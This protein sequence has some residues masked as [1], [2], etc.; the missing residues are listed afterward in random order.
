MIYKTKITL[1]IHLVLIQYNLSQIWYAYLKRFLRH[2]LS[3]FQVYLKWKWFFIWT[4]DECVNL[5][6]KLLS[7]THGVYVMIRQFASYLNYILLFTTISRIDLVWPKMRKFII[8]FKKRFRSVSY[9]A[10]KNHVPLPR[11]PETFSMWYR[12]VFG[13]EQYRFHYCCNL[14]WV[15]Q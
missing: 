15:Y 10:L 1:A 6:E 5:C 13:T 4:Q 3:N 2:S 11:F 9:I 14:W 7:E 8:F 12:I